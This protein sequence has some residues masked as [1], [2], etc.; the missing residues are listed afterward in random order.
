MKIEQ[1][2]YMNFRKSIFLIGTLLVFAILNSCGSMN[3]GKAGMTAYNIGEYD[4]AAVQFQKAYRKEKDQN[5]KTEYEFYMADALLR[6]GRYSQSEIRFR[7]LVRKNYPSKDV[8]ITYADVLRTNGK[9]EEAIKIYTQYLDS[10][11]GDQRALN[12]IESCKVTPQWE[13]TPTR[14]KVSVEQPINSRYADFGPSYAGSL[15]NKI[16]FT[17][18]RDDATGKRKSAITGQRFADLY[19]TN[20]DVQK[21]RWDK[22]VRIDDQSVVNTNEEEGAPSVTSNGATLYFT[23]SAYSK[24]EPSAPQIYT[25]RFSQG[26]WSE[27]TLLK[28]V[29]DTI[30]AAHPSIS[31]DGF[32]LFFVSDME[33]GYGGKDIWR[34][35]QQDGEWSQPVNLGPQVNTPGN[36]MFPF[37]RDNGDLYFSSDYHVGMGGLDIFKATPSR[38]EKDLLVWTVENMKAPINSRGDDFG[39]AFIPSRDEGMLTSNRP[40]SR[41]DDIYSF[42][43]PPKIYR[44]EGEIVD[45]NTGNRISN[46]YIRIIGTDGTMLKVRSEDGKFQYKL[47]P[48]TEYIVAAFKDGFLNA[49]TLINTEGYDDSKDFKI[50]LNLTP[51]DAPI[52][53]ENISYEF[54]RWDLTPGSLASLDSLV[55]LLNQNPTIV[56][57]LMSHTDFIGSTAF[58]SDLSQKR[59]QSAVDY[60]IQKGVNP[61][62]VVAKGYGETW[63]KV[64]TKA[65]AEKHSFLKQG[66]ELT[67]DFI[68]KLAGDEQKEIAKALCRRTEFRVLR[69]DFR[70]AYSDK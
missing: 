26:I 28:V 33:G 30:M 63:P 47:N 18:T 9:Y 58:N 51:T 65:I 31:Y 32:S 14:F 43:L 8:L 11:P 4:D 64:V 46:A 23:R 22:P 48:N 39:I 52:N 3:P 44:A 2:M 6:I 21:Q 41:G 59:A 40:G 19:V 20:F 17:S 66:D 53:V 55:D 36:E 37:I 69:N 38:D 1:H 50:E 10:V 56:I 61:R 68:N 35:D 62:R 67:E 70:E 42:A 45:A 54:G 13:S 29:P 25:A 7:N 57:E 5:K 24:T 12:G 49:K 16:I 60:L 27:P 15:G 34:V